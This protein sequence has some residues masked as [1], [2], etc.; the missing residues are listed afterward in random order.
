MAEAQEKAAPEKPDGSKFGNVGGTAGGV[1]EFLIGFA[2]LVGGGYLFL[3]QVVVMSGFWS[4]FGMSSFGL[5]LI[6]IFIGVALLFFD[7][8]S[9]PGWLLT[10]GGMVAIFVGVLAELHI[11]FKPTSLFNTLMMLVLIAGGIGLIA[12]AIRPHTAR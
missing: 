2:M 5:T 7:G 12:R 8:K 6:P 11:H 1:G 4:L 9:I 3:N 10:G